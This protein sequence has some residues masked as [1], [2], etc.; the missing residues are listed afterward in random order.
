M[1][2]KVIPKRKRKKTTSSR[3]LLFN[4]SKEKNVRKNKYDR[5]LLKNVSIILLPAKTGY[6]SSTE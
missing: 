6:L 4:S 3:R 1:N 5:Q 2:A